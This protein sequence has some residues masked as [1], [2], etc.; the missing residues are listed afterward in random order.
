MDARTGAQIH[1]D[2]V[3][4][5][6]RP[7]KRY[8]PRHRRMRQGQCMAALRATTAARIYLDGRASSLT[9]AALGCGSSRTYVQAAVVLLQSENLVMLERVLR[10][11]VPL[12]VA[13]KQL[14][15]IAALVDAYRAA[16]A[17]DR[18]E[19]ARTIGPTT[20]FDGAVA[21]AL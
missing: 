7:K 2:L 9:A 18:V 4:N 8:R 19:F 3:R 6:P 11:N 10:G 20:L 16:G 1:A 14:K 13:A 12:L 21:L 5:K 17:A 15:Q